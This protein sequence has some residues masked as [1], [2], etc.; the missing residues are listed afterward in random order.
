M[1]KAAD[2]LS[3]PGYRKGF[4]SAIG[5]TP[6]PGTLN[7]RLFPSY[8]K[9]TSSLGRKGVKLVR[10]FSANGKRFGSVRCY[11]ALINGRIA[12]FLIRP[13]R[14]RY[15][16]SIVELVSRKRLKGSRIES[17]A[18]VSIMVNL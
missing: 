16:P 8:V 17:G 1:G 9:K 10:G 14:S 11:R 15:P 3:M 7:V 12:A 18:T 6:Y 2:F 4:K 5:Y 13:A